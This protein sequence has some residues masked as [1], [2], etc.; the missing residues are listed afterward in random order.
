MDFRTIRCER[1]GP[2]AWITLNRPEKLNAISKTMVAE[3]NQAMDDLQG[4]EHVR[5]ILIKGEGRAFSAGFDLEPE[6]GAG[7]TRAEELAALRQELRDD[8]DLIMRFW[9]SPKPTIAQVDGIA[10]AAFLQRSLDT[11]AV[12]L[13]ILEF[14]EVK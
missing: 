6:A 12:F 14:E 3:L 10:T 5:I 8:F 2:L 4:D 11:V 1:D 9:D 7:R 13:R